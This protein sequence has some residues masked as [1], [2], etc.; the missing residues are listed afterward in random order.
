MRTDEKY[1]RK[2]EEQRQKKFTKKPK[3][4]RD[5]NFGYGNQVIMFQ[6]LWSEAKNNKAEVI[7]PF[8]GQDITMYRSGQIWFN[9]FAH[10][11]PKK[12]YPYFK[13]NPENVRVVSPDFHKIIDQGTFADR[14]R[15]PEW[16]WDEGDALVEKMKIAYQ[17]YKKL[18]LLP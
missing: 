13:L 6:N 12:N 11:L 9:C 14:Q 3:I 10:I 5:I 16:K 17:E 15:H 4:V 8:S 7:C 2:K 1:L 18:N